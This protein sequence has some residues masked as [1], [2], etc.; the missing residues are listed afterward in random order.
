MVYINSEEW[1]C[2]EM[3]FSKKYSVKP[4]NELIHASSTACHKGW[5]AD[6]EVIADGFM[7]KSIWSYAPIIVECCGVE[8]DKYRKDGRMFVCDVNVELPIS[9]KLMIGKSVNGS[10]QCLWLKKT[11]VLLVKN[12]KVME[13]RRVRFFEF[14][15]FG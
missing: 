5:Y 2:N 1:L 3:V 7:L 8:Y 10:R 4:V 15:G 14:L 11:M 13:F 9:K 6:Y 12:G